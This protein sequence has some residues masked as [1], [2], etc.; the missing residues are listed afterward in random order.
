VFQVAKS[1]LFNTSSVYF[2]TRQ[3]TAIT[4]LHT[5][6]YRAGRKIVPLNIGG[7]LTEKSFGCVSTSTGGDA[8]TAY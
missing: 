2:V 6:F 4:G 8:P 3:L 7:L 5:L 1:K